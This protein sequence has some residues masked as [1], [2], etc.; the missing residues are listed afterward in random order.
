VSTLRATNWL[1]ALYG[2]TPDADGYLLVCPLGD[3]SEAEVRAEL[4]ARGYTATDRAG[5][6][7]VPCLAV[8]L[9]ALAKHDAI[10]ANR[11][12]CSRRILAVWSENRQRSCSLGVYPPAQVQACAD[13]IAAHVAAENAAADLI[14]AAATVAAVKGVQ[15]V[16]P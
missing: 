6:V 8:R 7:A 2:G 9:L 13:W 12:E 10:E 1:N 16:W 4:W 14:D 15:P 11:A 3:V 5:H